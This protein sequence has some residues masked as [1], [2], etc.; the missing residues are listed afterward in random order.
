MFGTINLT[1][2]E[3][4]GIPVVL[5]EVDGRKTLRSSADGVRGL[6]IAHQ[7][8]NENPGFVTTRSNVRISRTVEVDESD[9]QVKPYVQLTISCPRGQVDL[10]AVAAMV[11]E[12]INFLTRGENS[13]VLADVAPSP[14]AASTSGL[15]RLYAGEP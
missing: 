13:E 3:A 7:E 10:D 9:K 4:T 12:L 1:T 14:L 6:T 15:A 5:T 2:A 11:S 8:S